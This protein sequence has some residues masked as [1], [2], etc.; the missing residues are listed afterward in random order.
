MVPSSFTV[1]MASR[2]TRFFR[3]ELGVEVLAVNVVDEFFHMLGVQHCE[4]VINISS[5]EAGYGVF[6]LPV[7]FKFLHNRSAVRKC[8]GFG[9]RLLISTIKPVVQYLQY[10]YIHVYGKQEP[11]GPLFTRK[12]RFAHVRQPNRLEYRSNFSVF[13]RSFDVLSGIWYEL[14]VMCFVLQGRARLLGHVL[15]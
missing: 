5:P 4:S 14:N 10:A 3:C 9:A 12:W 8:M 13:G 6:L 7:H 11:C 15:V 1:I 2:S